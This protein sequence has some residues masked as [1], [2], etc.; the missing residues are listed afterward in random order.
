MATISETDVV[1]FALLIS[2]PEIDHCST[3]RAAV[4]RHHAARKFKLTASSA[5]LAQV[6]AL[7]RSRLEKRPLRL[8][9]GRFIAIMT[10]RRGRKLVRQGSVSTG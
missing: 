8:A 1:V 9:D 10:G 4:S 3:K 6:T 7:R 2:M 5:A